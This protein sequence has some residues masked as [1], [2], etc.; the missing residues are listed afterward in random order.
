LLDLCRSKPSK[1]EGRG[2]NAA[3]PEE[4]FNDVSLVNPD[5]SGNVVSFGDRYVY[6]SVSVTGKLGNAVIPGGVRKYVN[7]VNPDKSGNLV[8]F[9]YDIKSMI[10]APVN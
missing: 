10:S 4:V 9:V 3:I 7:A 5:K 8:S 2:G 6:N 1:E